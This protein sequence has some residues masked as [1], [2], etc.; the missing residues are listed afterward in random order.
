M[1][2]NKETYTEQQPRTATVST[3]LMQ[4]PEVSQHFHSLYLNAIRL[5]F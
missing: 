2:G 5:V 3:R 1:V 4:K